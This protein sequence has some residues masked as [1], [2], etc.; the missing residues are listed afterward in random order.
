VYR[1][2]LT[3]G[4]KV[5]LD[6]AG[7]QY[8]I[9][10]VTVLPWAAYRERS[11]SVIKYSLPFRSHHVKHNK[12]VSKNSTAKH[13][14]IIKKQ[15]ESVN[16]LLNESD[17]I[18]GSDFKTMLS[19][20]IEIFTD[21]K[22]RLLLAA[23]SRL[24]KHQQNVETEPI[25]PAI[26]PLDRIHDCPAMTNTSIG[27]PLLFHLWSMGKFDWQ[28]L[29]DMVKVTGP[30]VTYREKKKAKALLQHRC[31]YRVPGNWRLI[32]IADEMPSSQVPSELVS[33]NPFWLKRK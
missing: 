18:L 11:A 20:D 3:D 16:A 6:L 25:E 30:E 5:A 24:A 26:A 19:Q 17:L 33:E 12:N 10:H 21:A 31:V 28:K 15:I 27:E 32:F 22:Q 29:V 1:I 2:A 8:N 7:T 9:P 23:S 13:L 4:T 14:T